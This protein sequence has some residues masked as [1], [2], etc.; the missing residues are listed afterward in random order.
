VAKTRIDARGVHRRR[1]NHNARYL[2][3]RLLAPNGGEDVLGEN[4][5]SFDLMH[6]DVRS[7]RRAK[8]VR[9]DDAFRTANRLVMN[10]RRQR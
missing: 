5:M 7:W 8:A 4:L 9:T 3:L 10:T 2:D 1:F 6:G